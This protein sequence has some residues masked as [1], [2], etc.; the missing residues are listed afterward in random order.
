LLIAIATLLVDE[1]DPSVGGKHNAQSVPNLAPPR[2][3]CAPDKR[4]PLCFFANAYVL[5]R[6]RAVRGKRRMPG[7]SGAAAAGWRPL[8]RKPTFAMLAAAVPPRGA[9]QCTKTVHNHKEASP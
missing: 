5:S 4:R 3:L 9:S 1:F 7:A 6:Q 2:A 8:S